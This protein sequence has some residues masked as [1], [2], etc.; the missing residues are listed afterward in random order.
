MCIITDSAD[1]S[2]KFNGTAINKIPNIVKAMTGK[3]SIQ[4][5][6]KSLM[7][8]E[9]VPV[10]NKGHTDSRYSDNSYMQARIFSIKEDGSLAKSFVF[11][12]VDNTGSMYIGNDWDVKM[13]RPVISNQASSSG[14]IAMFQGA[15]GR[16]D[17][18]ISAKFPVQTL[19]R[20]GAGTDAS[21]STQN[22]TDITQKGWTNFYGNGSLSLPT[23]NGEVFASAHSLGKSSLK[24]GD[25]V[26]L[27]LSFIKYTSDGKIE[28]DTEKDLTLYTVT[29]DGFNHASMTTG[30]LDNDG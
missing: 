27:T 7:F 9:R 21:F 16:N 23:Y 17:S 14:Y 26:T 4:I 13:T 15:N 24:N 1:A 10:F 5:G 2:I 29:N 6:K 12:P 25:P 30:D 20:S 3:S 22:I 8:L 28:H 11:S 19:D 18:S